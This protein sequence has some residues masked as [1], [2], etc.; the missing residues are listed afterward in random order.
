MAILDL[1][2]DGNKS[3]KAHTPAPGP[4]SEPGWFEPGSRSEALTRGFAQGATLGLAPRIS[5]MLSPGK[6]GDNLKQYLAA[7]QVAQEAHPGYTLA[8]NLAGGA[9][10]MIYG[11]AGTL[12]VQIA[13][14]AGMSAADTLGNST[15]TGADLAKEVATG[16][17]IGGGATAALP[18]LG[19]VAKGVTNLVVGSP[20]TE[21]IAAAAVKLGDKA[22]MKPPSYA[23]QAAHDAYHKEII[24]LSNAANKGSALKEILPEAMKQSAYGAGVGYVGSGGDVDAALKGG[25]A[26]L[27]TGALTGGSR[28]LGGDT[29]KLR[30]PG[31]S[32]ELTAIIDNS[33]P[34]LAAGT[35]NQFVGQQVGS[36]VKEAAGIST[37]PFG[38]LSDYIAQASGSSNPAVT[39]AA[40]QAQAAVGDAT[41]EDAKRKAAMA[42]QSTPE[43]RAV[44]NSSSN[45]RDLD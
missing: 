10:S 21:K 27:T 14:G 28:V 38:R 40:E 19:K 3:V 2:D 37:S 32:D 1:E 23:P 12:P 8:G 34:N 16:G 15:K 20:S 30:M 17:A 41:D 42:L 5:A 44:G 36:P 22:P 18:I 43:G 13:K 25:I 6:F 39:D 24:D 9:P 35:I 7:N 4:T 26:G 29:A 45:V 33:V 31:K 11:G